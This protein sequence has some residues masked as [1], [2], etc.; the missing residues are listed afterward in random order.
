LRF[1]SVWHDEIPL[2]VAI[3]SGPE[4]IVEIEGVGRLE[5][6]IM[7]EGKVKR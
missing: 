2:G 3:K 4:V 1:A 6:E 5:N 7:R